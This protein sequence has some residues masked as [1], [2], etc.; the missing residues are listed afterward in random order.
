[1]RLCS[2]RVPTVEGMRS[3]RED[4]AATARERPSFSEISYESGSNH[5]CGILL[6]W[7][8]HKPFCSAHSGF[9]ALIISTVDAWSSCPR[10]RRPGISAI[11]AESW[12]NGQTYCAASRDGV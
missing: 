11:R 2:D 4:I 6:S 7:H 8:W 9:R 12:H 10:I 5:C 1:M 3:D